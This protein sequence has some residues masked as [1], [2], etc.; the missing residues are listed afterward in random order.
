MFD[1]AFGVY[2]VMFLL[3][4]F[5]FFSA[6]FGDLLFPLAN[7]LSFI[8]YNFF[9]FISVSTRKR[10]HELYR[11]PR[12]S[13]LEANRDKLYIGGLIPGSLGSGRARGPA[14]YTGAYL[15][16]WLTLLRAN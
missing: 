6:A 16:E 5:F 3:L 7:I 4:Y 10:L 2:F 1:S 11:E 12:L 13:N 15:L 9:F 8:Y 14:G